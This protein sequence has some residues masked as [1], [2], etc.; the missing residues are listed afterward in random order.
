MK[1][2]EIKLQEPSSHKLQ[3]VK[4]VKV[5]SGLGLKVSKDLVDNLHQYPEKAHSMPIRDWETWD[6]NTGAKTPAVR[7]YLQHFIG[8]LEL[9]PSGKFTIT[10]GK[11]WTRDM[12]LMQLGMADKD[13]IIETLS[14]YILNKW[15]DSKEVL[16]VALS[17]LEIWELIEVVAMIKL[18]RETGGNKVG[19]E[20]PF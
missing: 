16:E 8:E 3:L 1:K 2:I 7:D 12:K 20:G 9:L 11:E 13:S 4:L 10:G 18:E 17:K 6:T 19:E 5:C 14:D 15:S